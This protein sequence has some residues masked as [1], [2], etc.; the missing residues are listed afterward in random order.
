MY[1]LV[2]F[3]VAFF[4]LFRNYKRQYHLVSTLNILRLFCLVHVHLLKVKERKSICDSLSQKTLQ[5]FWSRINKIPSELEGYF[6]LSEH[7]T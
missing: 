4:C 3:N 5:E 7:D 2:L 1:L 6:H